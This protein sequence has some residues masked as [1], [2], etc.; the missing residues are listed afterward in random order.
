MT[1]FA[2]TEKR[3]NC[4][5]RKKLSRDSGKIKLKKGKYI[6]YTELLS[7]PCIVL[8]K[9]VKCGGGVRQFVD[10]WAVELRGSDVAK[11]ST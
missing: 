9:T 3:D 11:S 7:V 10:P 8:L 5:F 1:T 4:A 6:G 2:A